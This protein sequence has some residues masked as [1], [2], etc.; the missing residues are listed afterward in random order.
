MT[1]AIVQADSVAHRELEFLEDLI[2]R[3]EAEFPARAPTSIQEKAAQ[4]ALAAELAQR[5]LEVERQTFRFSRC[6]Y[7]VVALHVALVVIGSA[8]YLWQP[9]IAVL[10]QSFAVVSYLLDCHYRGYWLRR[11][12]P[13]GPSQN[14]IARLPASG[15]IRRRVVFLAHTDAAPAGW[16]FSPSLLWLVHTNWRNGLCLLRKHMFGWTLLTALLIALDIILALTGYWFPGTYYIAT[17]SSAVPLVLATQMALSRKIVPGANDNLSG[18]AALVL[19]S[20][21]LSRHTPQGVEFV[22]VITGCEESGRGGA[23]A[24]ER[25]MRDQWDRRTTTIIGL[26]MLSGGVLRY[27][28]EGE[29]IPLWPSANLQALVAEAAAGDKRFEGLKPYCAPAG[30]TDAAPFLWHGYDGLCLARV[31]ERSDLPAYV[32]TMEDRAANIV[33]RDI[34]GAVDYAERLARGIAAG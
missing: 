34:Q 13:Q 5:G 22:F 2:H 6:L 4:E 15:R 25:R 33:P 30:A 31:E 10:L 28:V 1:T 9:W 14:I 21:R 3:L 29:V 12:L 8:C 27:H 7:S 16:M 11:L 20:E 23:A 32:H 26:D 18:C 17:L 19:L 24:L